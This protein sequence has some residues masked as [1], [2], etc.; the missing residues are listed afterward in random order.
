MSNAN[1]QLSYQPNFRSRVD[2]Q[3]RLKLEASVN[4]VFCVEQAGCTVW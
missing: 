2:I 1:E 4:A 3:N